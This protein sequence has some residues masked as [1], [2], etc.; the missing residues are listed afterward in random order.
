[1]TLNR[2]AANVPRRSE[3][4]PSTHRTCPRHGLLPDR[5]LQG[6]PLL[7]RRAPLPHRHQLRP[8][9]HQRRQVS[10]PQL[11]PR[12]SHAL[13]RER[14]SSPN[15]EPTA[16]AARP[17]PEYTERP[18]STATTKEVA[19]YNHRDGNDDYTQPGNLWRIFSEGEKDR[20]ATTIAKSLG[21]TP[22]R[23]QKLQLSHF[24]KADPDYAYRVAKALGGNEHPEY[25]HGPTPP[26]SPRQPACTRSKTTYPTKRGLPKTGQ[27]SVLPHHKILS[28]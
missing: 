26:R 13:R 3:Q 5:M 20:T 24:H 23:I 7:P 27:P 28:F 18:Y 17:E 14:G 11:Q 10:R 6:V 21:Q 19:R 22:L 9:P 4:P 16:S 15:Y 1:M 12:R 2:N 25:L 8:A